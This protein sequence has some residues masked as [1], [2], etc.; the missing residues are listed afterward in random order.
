MFHYVER[1]LWQDIASGVVRVIPPEPWFAWI[2]SHFPIDFNRIVWEKVAKKR[3][4]KVLET[5][6]QIHSDDLSILLA[7][8][9]DAVA[10]WI[11]EAGASADTEA[12]WIGDNAE[13]GVSSSA[14]VAQR[15]FPFL[16]SFPQHSYL[17]FPEHNAC[18]NYVMEGELFFGV[19]PAMPPKYRSRASR[20]PGRRF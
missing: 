12:I 2:E 18:L 13:S 11:S 16:M 14:S 15:N 7:R 5:P 19:A 20:S 4:L 1:T 6:R 8:H 10:S 17:L 3:Q 9:E